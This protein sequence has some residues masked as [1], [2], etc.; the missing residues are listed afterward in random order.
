MITVI[1]ILLGVFCSAME[2]LVTATIM[3]TIISELGGFALYPWVSNS[4]MLASVVTAPFAGS[5]A[6]SFG[7]KK[8]YIGGV[9]VFLLGS[10]LCGMAT[11]MPQMIAFRVIQGVGSSALLTLSLVLFGALF[12]IEKRAKMQ[13][14]VGAMWALA[15]LLGPALGAFLTAKFSWHWAFWINIPVGLLILLSISFRAAIPEPERKKFAMDY[16]GGFLFGLGTLGLVYGLMSIGK[17]N[18][19]V[20]TWG[21]FLA[22]IS[23]LVYFL[24]YRKKIEHPFIPFHLFERRAITLPVILA[25][26]AGFFLFSVANFTPMFVQGVLGEAAA[27]AGRVVTA[28]A[29]GSFT[30]AMLSGMLLNRLGF[31][32]I[33]IAGV[34][35]V[36]TGFYILFLQNSHALVYLL[37]IGNFAV[38]CG[39]SLIANGNMVA[40]QAASPVETL[41]SA[42]SMVTFSRTF[43]G[44]IGIAMMG[45][46]QLGLFHNGMEEIAGIDLLTVAET[47]RKMFDPIQR[48]TI[49]SQNLSEVVEVF[50]KSLHAVFLACGVLA[51]IS[52]FFAIKMP[53]NTP[54]EVS[55]NNV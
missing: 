46:L 12:P 49:L 4:F 7:Y 20:V 9:F 39:V 33:S 38:G 55:E 26:F 51:T 27:V 29:I 37:M 32:V 6:D 43:G 19:G 17:L 48:M 50:T 16:T 10:L 40:V 22:G 31:R 18:M 2:A 35:C 30:G 13:A 14:L 28:V 36:M 44:M 11:S 47:S 24:A 23:I 15:S 1:T 52:I 8:C 34:L 54:K 3:P 25:F 41:G 42:T 5:L 45:G 53:N 21:I